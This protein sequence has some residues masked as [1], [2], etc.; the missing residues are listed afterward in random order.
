MVMNQDRLTARAEAVSPRAQ[1]CARQRTVVPFRMAG[2]GTSR[3]VRSG[4]NS[5]L[6]SLISVSPV[7]GSVAVQRFSSNSALIRAGQC[8]PRQ[9]TLRRSDVRRVGKA[10]VHQ[11]TSRWYTSP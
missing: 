10:V 7:M 3:A 5:R 9:R 1:D 6:Y 11:D 2:T 4:V 8:T